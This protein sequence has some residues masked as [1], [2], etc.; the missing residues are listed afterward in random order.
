M[1]T[2][3]ICWERRTKWWDILISPCHCKG[4]MKYIHL[5]CYLQ[6]IKKNNKCTICLYNYYYHTT[7]LLIYILFC[8]IFHFNLTPYD[9]I[10]Y[11]FMLMIIAYYKS[12]KNDVIYVLRIISLTLPYIYN[13]DKLHF[14]LVFFHLYKII[15]DYNYNF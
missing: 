14:Y 12:Q 9:S 10:F 2:C 4:S 6:D 15:D 8:E 11:N 1:N 3:K 5:S 7:V 13:I